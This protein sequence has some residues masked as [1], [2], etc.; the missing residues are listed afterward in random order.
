MSI[1]MI[2]SSSDR[3]TVACVT[4]PTTGQ[5]DDQ[6]APRLRIGF[7]GTHSL[8]SQVVLTTL[9][10]HTP[11]TLVALPADEAPAPPVA[12][13]APPRLPSSVVDELVIVNNAVTAPLVQSAWQKQIPIYQ[14]QRL[15]SPPVAEW[16]AMQALDLVC[17]ACF[18]WR[19]PVTLLAL[20]TYGFMNVHPSLLPAYRGPAPLFWQLRAG[21]SSG[22]VTVHWM[23]ATLDTGPIAG[24]AA[25]PFPDGATSAELDR[26]FAQTGATLL[27]EVIGQLSAGHRPQ[28]PQTADGSQQSWPTADNFRL[29]RQWSARHAYNFMCGTDEW[30]QPYPITIDG[31]DRLLRQA[32]HY[33]PDQALG[34][35]MIRTGAE[36]AIQFAPGV[37]HALLW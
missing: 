37:L 10:D 18:P 22:G 2:E 29:D 31:A 20:P 27:L 13:W 4:K 9:L 12:L 17:V 33:Q 21:L 16:L 1:V 23:D 36:V 34:Q 25:L 8:F 6:L 32:L 5:A 28:Q 7:W 24:Q 26:L 30:R 15:R 35:A 14:V 3:T 19:I 11:L